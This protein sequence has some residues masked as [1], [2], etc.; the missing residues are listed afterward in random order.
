MWP[1]GAIKPKGPFPAN[2]MNGAI[3]ANAVNGLIAG[4]GDPQVRAGC[5]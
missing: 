5:P 4:D 2:A 1:A 3:W